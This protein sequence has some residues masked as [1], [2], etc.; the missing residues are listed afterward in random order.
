MLKFPLKVLI[1]GV[2]AG[3]AAVLIQ[4]RMLRVLA[5]GVEDV[6]PVDESHLFEVF[7]N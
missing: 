5:E 6:P 3:A 2:A 7:D 4:Y 1:V